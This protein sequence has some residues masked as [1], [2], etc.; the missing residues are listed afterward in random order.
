MT[1]RTRLLSTMLNLTKLAAEGKRPDSLPSRQLYEVEEYLRDLDDLDLNRDQEMAARGL[2]G[3]S[4]FSVDKQYI[5]GCVRA[6]VQILIQ[7]Q[8]VQNM[9]KRIEVCTW[10]VAGCSYDGCCLCGTTCSPLSTELLRPFLHIIFSPPCQALA[11][12]SEEREAIFEAR[13]GEIGL[14]AT[15]LFFLVRILYS[16]LRGC[17]VPKRPHVFC[18]LVLVIV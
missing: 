4:S 1:E 18:H 13:W 17:C 12:T 2:G 11:K 5:L 6:K 10:V 8:W 9:C 14:M 3:S 16:L 7:G 15:C